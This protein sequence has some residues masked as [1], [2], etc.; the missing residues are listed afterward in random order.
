[1]LRLMNLRGGDAEQALGTFRKLHNMVPDN[2]EVIF[3][4]GPSCLP[5]ETVAQHESSTCASMVHPW[6]YRTCI[7]Q[8][9]QLCGTSCK[10]LWN[11]EPWEGHLCPPSLQTPRAH[12]CS[13]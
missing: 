7:W 5:D 11:M 10:G 2:M 1:M 3:Q 12:T 13:T 9:L 4:V 8:R 6:H